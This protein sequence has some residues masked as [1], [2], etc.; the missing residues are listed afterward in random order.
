MDELLVYELVSDHF[1]KSTSGRSLY[2]KLTALFSQL[3]DVVNWK[4]ISST[5]L[6]EN[7]RLIVAEIGRKFMPQGIEFGNIV[8]AATLII[9]TTPHG[10]VGYVHDVVVDKHYRAN[11]VGKK[12][13]QEIIRIAQ[14]HNL[15]ELNLTTNAQ[16]RPS[17]EALYLGL[18]FSKKPT[19]FYVLKLAQ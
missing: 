13:M 2:G 10:P 14:I 8:G 7:S 6:S 16:K 5:V 9:M 15:K 18:G 1:A 4:D 12:L 3:L 11:G 17:A 19:G